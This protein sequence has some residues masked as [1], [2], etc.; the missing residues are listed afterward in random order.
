M[1][2]WASA[3]ADRPR[4]QG[5]D[6]RAAQLARILG[7]PAPRPGPVHRIPSRTVG[8]VRLE[9]L[10]WETGIG[11]TTGAWLARPLE[12]S[13]DIPGVLALHSHGGAMWTGADQ[14]VAPGLDDG[15]P[16]A[17]AHGRLQYGGAPV[18]ELARRGYAVLAHDAFAWGTRRIPADALSEREREL[19]SALG[20]LRLSEGR[21]WSEIDEYNTASALHEEV[22]EKTASLLGS[23]FAGVVASDDLLA[24]EQLSRIPGVDPGRLGAF[25]FS[26]GGGRALFLGV[27]DARVR[28][29]VTVAMMT[30][31]R[32]MADAHARFH[33]WLI[34]VPGLAREIDLPDLPRL[35]AEHALLVQYREHDELF[36]LHGMREAHERLRSRDSTSSYEGSFFPGPHAFDPEM[37]AEAWGFLDRR[38]GR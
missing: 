23:S 14:F 3:L 6:D 25:G 16:Y 15:D 13:G 1:S 24:L 8:D 11:P 4:L 19:A 10:S 34:N 5:A 22:L 37:Q 29:T 28:A 27:L 21:P 12:A 20:R 26:G 7:V 9:R 18:L 36:P 38:L 30:T 35:D 2:A 33:S 17:A 31:W 32:S